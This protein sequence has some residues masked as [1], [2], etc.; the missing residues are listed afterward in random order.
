MK[1]QLRQVMQV[2]VFGAATVMAGPV[3]AAD[4]DKTF[5]AAIEMYH[6]H[7]AS[8]DEW[9]NK[10]MASG[11]GRYATESADVVLTAALRIYTRDVLDR[12]YWVNA[13]VE[14]APG[15]DSG[16][17]LLAV[18]QGSGV[19]LMGAS[20]LRLGAAPAAVRFSSLQ[21]ILR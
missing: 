1:T 14:G 8:T 3:S 18:A 2:A 10:L 11:T 5:N 13:W 16:N 19:T 12:G 21:G 15:Y 17:P 4:S 9:Q 7:S 6:F 20:D